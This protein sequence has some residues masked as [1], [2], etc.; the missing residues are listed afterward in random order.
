VCRPTI[1]RAVPTERT[2]VCQP[3][4]LCPLRRE[5]VGGHHPGGGHLNHRASAQGVAPLPVQPVGH[6][7]RRGKGSA[8]CLERAVIRQ[9]RQDVL[10]PDNLRQHVSTL[11]EHTDALHA[12]KRQ[13]L[14]ALE[15]Q[16]AGARRRA[17]RLADALAQ[18]PV[19]ETLLCKFDEAEADARRLTEKIAATQAELAYYAH[20]ELSDA[21]LE[22]ICDRLA[23]AFNAGDIH[24][25]SRDSSSGS[26]LSRVN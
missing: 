12:E 8:N 9:L 22:V 1:L 15:K 18:R 24:K 5:D 13:H 25:Q 6:N 7:V 20:V 14:G 11:L 16:L 19:S 26:R 17:G 23:Y 10:T 3:G 2:A 21:D 4:L